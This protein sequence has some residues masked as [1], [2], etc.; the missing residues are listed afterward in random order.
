MSSNSPSS[1]YR[2][3]NVNVDC[4]HF[5]MCSGVSCFGTHLE[6]IFL[7]NTCSVTILCNKER[8]MTAE[9]HNC[10]ATI[11]HNSFPHKLHE[12][13][14][15]DGWSPTGLLIMHM[16]SICCKLSAPPMRHLHAHYIR[17]IDLAQL[18]LYIDWCYAMC[19]Q[20]LYHRPNSTVG[21][22]WNNSLHLEPLQRFSWENSGSSVCAY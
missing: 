19:I 7:N 13:F 15:N 16:L 4:M 21:G 9:V 10:E 8:E 5:A 1:Y 2:C 17:P 20:R 22:S 18:M 11:L 14:R 3:R 12:V 6:H